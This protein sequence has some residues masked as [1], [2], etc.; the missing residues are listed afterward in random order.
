MYGVLSK[1]KPGTSGFNSAWKALA[2]TN[3]GRFDQIQHA[4]IKSSHFDPAANKIKSSLGF[5]VSKYSTAVQNVLWSTAV[6]HGSGGAVN[7]FRS[8]GIKQGMS[9]AEII[10]RVYAERAANNGA[11]YFSRSSSDIRKSV[12]NRFKNEMQDA[13]SMLGK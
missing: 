7:V 8:A 12:V 11:K 3:P 9:D 6:Q 5:D 13:L 1:Y 2:G 4:F 10:R